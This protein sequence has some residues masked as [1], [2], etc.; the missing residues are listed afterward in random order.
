MTWLVIC[1]VLDSMGTQNQ[2]VLKIQGVC[3]TYLF[4]SI[5]RRASALRICF[6]GLLLTALVMA[7]VS[8]GGDGDVDGDGANPPPTNASIPASPSAAAK[9][10]LRP[11][12]MELNNSGN[13]YLPRIASDG[14]GNALA[15]WSQ[16]ESDVQLT[17]VWANRY[18]AGVGWGTPTLI[19]T[20]NEN[21][22]YQPQIAFDSNG[23]AMTVWIQSGITSVNIW[24]NRYVAGSGW[25]EAELIENI[26]SRSVGSLQL[27][28]SSSGHGLAVWSQAGTDLSD[29]R[30][31]R[32]TLGTGWGAASTIETNNIS[33]AYNP[34]I[35][36]DSS[37]NGVAVWSQTV[38]SQ[39]VGRQHIWANRYT[40]GKGWGTATLVENNNLDFASNPKI[41]VDNNG[42]ALAVWAQAR[43]TASG[44]SIWSN[45]YTA[46]AGWGTAVLIET[47]NTGNSNNPQI[48]MD[49]SGNALVIWEH[50]SD[51]IRV[52]R[53]TSGIGWGTVTA[54]TKNLANLSFEPQIGMDASGNAM[55]IWK[56]SLGTFYSIWASRY[57]K[58]VGWS[59]A[60][61]ITSNGAGEAASP[62]VA[63]D[64]SGNVLAVW[65]EFDGTSSNIWSNS[66]R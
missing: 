36:M 53:Y 40:S 65:S 34:Q 16:S 14:R 8:C 11:S 39:G 6:R 25:G 38:W 41:A 49:S 5:A 19:E 46:G 12:L 1:C 56:Q 15:V 20:D 54:I 28:M 66:Y 17:S 59:K 27:A 31:K 7:V 35:A 33:D 18:V 64:D 13:A 26:P 29:I 2:I 4:I 45:R 24:A 32:Y 58:G 47:N 9:V 62:Q 55:A 51:G 21:S 48:A 22:T 37:G 10:W 60:A 57:I 3:M 50:T 43:N 23:N 52:N 61:A 42:N 44:I 30:A 63:V